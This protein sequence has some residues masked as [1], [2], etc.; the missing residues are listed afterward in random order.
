MSFVRS[1]EKNH[2]IKQ[3]NG[4]WWIWFEDIIEELKKR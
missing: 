1:E 4:A 3:R 2:K